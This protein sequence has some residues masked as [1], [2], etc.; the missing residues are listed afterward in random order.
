MPVRTEDMLLIE[1]R[2]TNDGKSLGLAFFLWALLGL[3]GAHRFYVGRKATG[4]IFLLWFFVCLF[5]MGIHPIISTVLGLP[6][7]IWCVIDAFRLPSMVRAANDQMRAN[8]LS[9]MQS[10][11]T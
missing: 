3:T 9:K 4:V 7:V 2:V 10:G 1:Q 5:F 8:L 11:L 6:L